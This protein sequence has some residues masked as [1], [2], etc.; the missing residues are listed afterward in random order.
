V[1]K[2]KDWAAMVDVGYN[3]K[4]YGNISAICSM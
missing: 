2:G 3:D 1:I 4:D